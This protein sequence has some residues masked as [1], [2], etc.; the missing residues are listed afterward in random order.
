MKTADGGRVARINANPAG[1]VPKR[2]VPN[3]EVTVSGLRGDRQRDRRYHGGPNRAV[4]V[5]ALERIE[6]LRAEGHP[7]EPGSCG[8]NLTVAGIDWAS[9]AVGD[10]LRIGDEVR[11]EVTGFASP[12]SKIAAS[13]TEGAF[14]RISQKL[15]P[16]WSRIYTRV[17]AEGTVREGDRVEVQRGS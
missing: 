14:T 8:E 15:H 3:A 11:L 5:Y 6:A 13:F 2:R 16:A 10:L 9:L 17:L 4:S 1:G 7:I 12:C